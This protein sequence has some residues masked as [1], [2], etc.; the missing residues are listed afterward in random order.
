MGFVKGLPP[1]VEF[2]EETAELTGVVPWQGV[3]DDLQDAAEFEWV[4]AAGVGAAAVCRIEEPVVG[5]AEEPAPDVQGFGG[6][7]WP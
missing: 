4:R 1:R 7:S 6:G 2:G 5:V 3:G